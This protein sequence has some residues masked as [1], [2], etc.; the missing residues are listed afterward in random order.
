MS[1]FNKKEKYLLIYDFEGNK[2]LK[3]FAIQYAK[4][5]LKDL[6]HQ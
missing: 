1:P 4:Q 3:E 6:L 2:E 5:K